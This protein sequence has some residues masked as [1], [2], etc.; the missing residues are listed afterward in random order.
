MAWPTTPAGTT[1]VDA[2][3]DKPS[4]ARAD[5]KQNIDNVNSIISEFNISSPSDGDL[6]Q[7]SS[8][9]GKWEQVASSTVGGS[10]LIGTLQTVATTWELVSGNIY[11]RNFT[12]GF[13]PSTFMAKNGDFQL[14]LGAGNY[15]IQAN[16]STS[17]INDTEA[18]MTV[19]DETGA[20]EIGI[21]AQYIEISST[22]DGV[23]EGQIG[24]TLS[25]QSNVSF[26]QDASS[27]TNRNSNL[28]IAVYKF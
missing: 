18:N 11:R 6:L 5:I 25:A 8:S 12:L 10:M 16:G 4:L 3:S 19:Y 9:S 15:L 14:T 13:N 23:F 21:L 20:S 27:S 17:A 28:K 24:F 7:Y 26:R 22:N 2:G 1:N